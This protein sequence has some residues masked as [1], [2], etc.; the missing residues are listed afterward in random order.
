MVNGER[1]GMM[2]MM[3]TLTYGAVAKVKS[4]NTCGVLRTLPGMQEAL[5]RYYI[6]LPLPLRLL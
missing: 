2:M 1:V 6:L 3:L 4:I 5:S